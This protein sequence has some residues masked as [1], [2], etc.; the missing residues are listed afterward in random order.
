MVVERVSKVKNA[1][2]RIR[3]DYVSLDT[4][5]SIK[6]AVA[7]VIKTGRTVPRQYIREM[8][9]DVSNLIPE[10]LRSVIDELYLWD[11]NISGSPRLIL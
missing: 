4:D 9:R 5:L 11:T 10:L 7:R 1:G 2:N 8:N 6:L 3:A